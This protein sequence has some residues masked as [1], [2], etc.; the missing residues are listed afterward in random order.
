MSLYDTLAAKLKSGRPIILDGGT[1]TD[2]QARGA[3]M[4]GDTWCA[5]VN[6]THPEIVQS[7]H[8]DY[9]AAG[10]EV[11]TANS[12][13][14]SVLSFNYYKRDTDVGVIDKA[15]VEIAKRAADGRVP[16]AGS[17]S[18]MRPVYPGTDRTVTDFNWTEAQARRLF[19]AKAKGLK[20]AGVDLIMMEM[21]RDTDYSIWA[22]QEAM[23]TGLPVWVGFS[24]EKDSQGRFTGFGR[25]DQ[26][27]ADFLPRLASLKPQVL[28]VMHSSPNDIGEALALIRKMWDGP[29]GAYP[30]S[31]YFAAPD[32]Q[33][34]GIIPPAE[35][36]AQA[37]Q[38][39][40]GGVSLIGGCCGIG[41]AHIRA[42]SEAFK[43]G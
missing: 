17:F 34:I 42:L 2:I 1:G 3:P 38:W 5:E 40:A 12:F 19:A 30:E 21:M 16:V 22:T 32:W 36:V 18:T 33:F 35:L 25:P 26:M 8:E 10:A 4:H 23:A 6:L 43:H 20:D 13:A 39:V 27:L 37:K 29:L 24:I 15:A 31:G 11:I 41:P 9:I 28:S 14:S 7:V